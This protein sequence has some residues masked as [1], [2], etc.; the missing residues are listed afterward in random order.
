M[1]RAL[2]AILCLIASA[3]TANAGTGFGTLEHASVDA[4]FEPGSRLGDD[5]SFLVLGGYRVTPESMSLELGDIRLDELVSSGGGGGG[6]FDPANPPPGY[7]LCHGGH[8]HHDDGRLVDYE[9]IQAELSSGG[10]SAYV[11]MATVVVGAERDLL[12]GGE[13]VLD[14]VLPSRELQ[15]GLI[16]RVSMDV[17]R[18]R[19]TGTVTG[20]A[21]G[22]ARLPIVVDVAVDGVLSTL[23]ADREISLDTPPEVY[24]RVSAPVAA[25][26]FDEQDLS[27]AVIDGQVLIEAGPLA[28]AVALSILSTPLGVELQ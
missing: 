6:V 24:L 16:S 11:T 3:C 9:D 20:G 17:A 18:F 10:A 8:C 4:R 12:V 22:E 1:I 15:Q 21:F 13:L 23:E 7:S 28:D 26:F 25:S 19:L 14:T 2:V 27:A 5:G